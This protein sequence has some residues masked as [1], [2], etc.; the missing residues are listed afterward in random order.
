MKDKERVEGITPKNDLEIR[1][2]DFL[3]AQFSNEENDMW[4]KDADKEA[5]DDLL[6][7]IENLADAEEKIGSD[8]Y[9]LRGTDVTY[10]QVMKFMN[11]YNLMP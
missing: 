1:V 5:N 3:L 6:S 11:D 9:R 8:D 4:L 2:K 7:Y 10:N